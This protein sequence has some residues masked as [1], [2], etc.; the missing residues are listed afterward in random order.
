[1]GRWRALMKPTAVSLLHLIK[2]QL[3]VLNETQQL[4]FP[5]MMAQAAIVDD[6]RMTH[7]M[8]ETEQA[9][10]IAEQAEELAQI[11]LGIEMDAAATA[12]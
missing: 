2:V 11:Q 9:A 12:A 3:G 5:T 7:E 1:M 6:M 8:M 10:F 4:T